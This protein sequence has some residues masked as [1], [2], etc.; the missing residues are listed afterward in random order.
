MI[1]DRMMCYLFNKNILVNEGKTVEDDPGAV[2]I[3]LA[4]L[5]NIRVVK[6]SGLAHRD[7]IRFVSELVYVN[8]PEP[9]YRGFP[10]SVR[11]LA[12]QELLYDQILNY[13]ITYGLG[14][15][16]QTRHSVFEE[17]VE[18]TVFS[19]ETDIREFV[20]VDEK[21]ALALIDKYVSDLCLSTRPL[22]TLQFSLVSDH[23]RHNGFIPG[24]VSSKDTA[25]RLIADLGAYGF[26][27]YLSMSDVIRLVD[28]INYT[29][30]GNNDMTN[31]NLRNKDR[32][33]I[34]RAIDRIGDGG[35][36]NTSECCEK[37]KM[38]AGLLHHI[39][40]VPKTPA[41][42][43]FVNIMRGHENLSAYS[44][45]ERHMQENNIRKAVDDLISSK[46]QGALMRSLNYILSRCG[47]EEEHRYVL[48][49]ADT[50]NGIILLQLYLQYRRYVS[51]RVPRTF[52][53]TKHNLS[54]VHVETDDEVRRRRSLLSSEQASEIADMILGKLRQVYKNRL[55]KVYIEPSMRR[56][57]V[58]LSESATQSGAGVLTKGSRIAIGKAKKIRAFTYW[59]RVDD[60]DLSAM[61]IDEKGNHIEFSWRTMSGVNQKDGAIVYSGDETSGYNGGSE[62]F[63]IDVEKFRREYPEVR[64]IVFCDNVYSFLTFDRCICRAGYMIRDEED[65]GNVYE[66][67]TVKSAYVVTGATRFCY[68]FAIDLTTDELVWINSAR[69][70]DRAVAG[71]TEFGFLIDQINIT[72][73][74]NMYDLFSMMASSV[75]ED[76]RDADVVVTDRVYPEDVDLNSKEII[77]EYDVERIMALMN[78]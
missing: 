42:E 58:P 55:G 50:R 56:Y 19:E 65:T 57:G 3:S 29:S 13:F 62:F 73:I 17:T 48:S 41:M 24:K 20:I 70:S 60:I 28:F 4:K 14:D 49:K 27:D 64:Y 51:E 11:E 45:F 30:Y 12:P 46:G 52:V 23:I 43:E 38:W 72:R 75:T 15:M 44:V 74:F 6:G 16:S 76:I 34:A 66:P 32:K 71:D 18:R 68:M 7:M 61:G 78:R 8:V 33:L 2:L 26:A 47:T 39:H 10:G 9:F 40:Y 63:D 67:K 22:N 59:E 36:I 35:R 25:V 1:S 69:D 77:R 53:F 31:L 21:E 37:R 5:F 54:C